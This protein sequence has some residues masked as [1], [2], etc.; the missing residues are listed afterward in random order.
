[1]FNREKSIGIITMHH[2]VRDF[3]KSAEIK[4]KCSILSKYDESKAW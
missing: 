1:M 4:H 3:E 2:T